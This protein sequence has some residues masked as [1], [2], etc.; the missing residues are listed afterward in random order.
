[1]ARPVETMVSFPVVLEEAAIRQCGCAAK[2]WYFV[3]VSEKV[4]EGWSVLAV[5]LCPAVRIPRIRYYYYKGT[6]VSY[7]RVTNLSYC[8]LFP[9]F[10]MNHRLT[11]D[12]HS[13]VTMIS[14]AFRAADPRAAVMVVTNPGQFGHCRSAVLQAPILPCEGLTVRLDGMEPASLLRYL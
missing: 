8:S 12:R 7:L 6:V 5:G 4:P 2:T 9:F 11:P 3:L 1:M 14:K 10:L 13:S